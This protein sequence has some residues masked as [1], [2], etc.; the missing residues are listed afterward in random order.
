MLVSQALAG[1]GPGAAAPKTVDKTALKGEALF[2]GFIVRDETGCIT[3]SVSVFS[4]VSQIKESAAEDRLAV[5]TAVQFDQ[6]QDVTHFQGF[7]M[8][9]TFTQEVANSLAS[10]SL[11]L[12]T[13]FTDF[14]HNTTIPVTLNLDFSKAARTA[15]TNTRDV[16]EADNV[17]FKTKSFSAEAPAVATGT[18]I[19]GTEAV[20][21]PEDFSLDA[22]IAKG[23]EKTATI[24]KLP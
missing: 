15:K 8:T 22:V 20:V 19:F 17:V 24:E 2:T 3:T 11:Q 4:N 14:A 16:F 10:G 21:S 13:T 12:E 6:C 5:V 9:S 1:A 18:I 23:T 7:G